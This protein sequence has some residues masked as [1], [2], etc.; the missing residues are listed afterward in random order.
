MQDVS[1]QLLAFFANETF[2]NLLVHVQT[3]MVHLK[4]VTACF[5][6]NLPTAIAAVDQLK[7]RDSQGCISEETYSVFLSS[8]L[9]VQKIFRFIACVLAMNPPFLNS[10]LSAHD[11][12]WLVTYKGREH[13]ERS[14]HEVINGSDFWQR[15]CDDCI[16][17]STTTTQL[18]P[19]M[20]RLLETLNSF[21]DGGLAAT[22]DRL[23]E[24]VGTLTEVKKGMRK[25]DLQNLDEVANT[26]FIAFARSILDGKL[27][28][29][30]RFVA[31]LLDGLSLFTDIGGT[32]DLQARLRQW[33]TTNGPKIALLDLVDLAQTTEKNG[34]VAELSQVQALMAKLKSV[35]DLQSEEQSWAATSLLVATFRSVFTEAGGRDVDSDM[36]PT[37]Y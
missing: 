29:R 31:A 13:L 20:E 1:A 37:S 5:L 2:I 14:L 6:K 26:V 36:T 18:R 28:A 8:L 4:V 11:V 32:S 15:E 22:P 19:K 12:A 35:K 3:Y 9:R 7:T 23:E 25:A 27:S 30:T 33:I 16:R 21:S 34:G 17:C 10:V 24:V